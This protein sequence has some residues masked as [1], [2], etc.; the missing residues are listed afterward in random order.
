MATVC[1]ASLALMDAGVPLAHPVAG[2]AMGLVQEGKE[3]ALFSDISGLEDEIGDMDFKVAGTARGI[4][5]LQMDLKGQA[6]EK[7][8]LQRALAQAQQ[9]RVHILNTMAIQSLDQ[10]RAQLSPH[11]PSVLEVQ[12]PTDKIRDLIGSGGKT[13]RELCESTG[14]KIDIADNGLVTV[15][16][17]NDSSG[18]AA[19]ARIKQLT[20]APE[21]G[22]VYKGSV[23][24]VMD[25][26]AFI[27]FGFA[28]DGMV[29]ISEISG[30]R[31]EDINS[32]LSVGDEVTVKMI[33]FDRG[34]AKLSIKQVG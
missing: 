4:T 30:E 22:G 12:I 18:L 27:S 21:A 11:A 8:F 5:A 14:A 6:L 17:Q 28:Q 9:G 32:V 2:I 31:I 1:G 23:V 7:S 33:G 20:D 25:F 3:M 34:R 10:P 19:V 24:K 15:F 16:A 13:I 29:H 26:G